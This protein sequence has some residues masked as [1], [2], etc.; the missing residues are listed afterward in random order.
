MLVMTDLPAQVP[1]SPTKKR[2][3]ETDI[4]DSPDFESTLM[5]NLTRDWPCMRVSAN[6]TFSHMGSTTRIFHLFPDIQHD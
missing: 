2:E 6:K 4:G 3:R 1:P 5:L